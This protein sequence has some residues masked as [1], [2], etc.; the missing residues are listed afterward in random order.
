MWMGVKAAVAYDEV[1]QKAF[2]PFAKFGDSVGNMV[3]NIPSY[4]PTPHPA[5]AALTPGG[6]TAMAGGIN[7]NV[8]D[9]INYKDQKTTADILGNNETGEIKG[10]AEN[11]KSVNGMTRYIDK[12]GGMQGG[13]KDSIASYESLKKTMENAK[14]N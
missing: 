9:R 2:A 8:T 1:T 7:K 14:T 10:L 6:V 11:T 3:Q 12:L 4:L 5:M 13:N